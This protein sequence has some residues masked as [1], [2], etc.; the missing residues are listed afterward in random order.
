M[1]TSKRII[2]CTLIICLLL[3]G[4]LFSMEATDLKFKRDFSGH[5]RPL[6]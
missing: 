1:N 5:Q 4:T 2:S 3:T 6:V